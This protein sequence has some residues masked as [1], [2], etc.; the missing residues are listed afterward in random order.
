MNFDANVE[1][2]HI[3]RW[4]QQFLAGTDGKPL[5][6][7]I[8]GGKDSTITAAALCEAVGPNRV[9]GVLM[10]NGTQKDINVSRAVCEHLGIQSIEVDIGPMYR[11]MLR[12]IKTS[13]KNFADSPFNSVVTSNAPCRCRTNTLYAIANQ[14]H[15][16]LVNTFNIS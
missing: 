7:G 12:S 5:V 8:S 13:A 11:A 14:H 16:R 1:A 15:V 10:P 3:I 2:A 4:A 6:I 9:L